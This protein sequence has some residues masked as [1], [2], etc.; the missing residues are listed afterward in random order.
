M[1]VE[2][3]YSCCTGRMSG[4]A[5]E[6]N[7]WIPGSDK[8]KDLPAVKAQCNTVFQ[9]TL[10][11]KQD[12]YGFYPNVSISGS[13]YGSQAPIVNNGAECL[14]ICKN[15][16]DCAAV[17][18]FPATGSDAGKF[19]CAQYPMNRDFIDAPGVS[20]AFVPG[21]SNVCQK[22]CDLNNPS[23]LSS[24]CKDSIRSACAGNMDNEYCQKFCR[25]TDIDC[26]AE[27]K[28]YCDGLGIDKAKDNPTC[29]CFL[30]ASFYTTFYENLQKLATIPVV[31]TTYQPSCSFPP[32]A[33]STIQPFAQKKLTKCPDL[34]QCIQVANVNNQGQ[35]TG[36]IDIKPTTACENVKKT[37]GGDKKEDKK[38]D[39]KD[40]TNQPK[41]LSTPAIVGIIVGSLIL[42]GLLVGIFS[43]IFKKPKTVQATK[44]S[45]ILAPQNLAPLRTSTRVTTSPAVVSAYDRWYSRKY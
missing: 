42:I 17:S 4:S 41:K 1:S 36:A 28:K 14:E 15:N 11:R 38:E 26:D 30:P 20:S 37:G 7:E 27:I 44:T 23:T 29:A 9:I 5:C 40:D 19:R 2:N 31:A 10:K 25:I 18:M 32:C 39:K 33:V 3:I 16:V 8:C 12:T 43:S 22:I 21:L 24:W 34:F 35:I 6:S 13:A 45:T